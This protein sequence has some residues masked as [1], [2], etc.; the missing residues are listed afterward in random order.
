MIFQ[1]ILEIPSPLTEKSLE[2]SPMGRS[3]IKTPPT[4]SPPE[5]SLPGED[6]PWTIPPEHSLHIKLSSQRETKTN[7]KNPIIYEFQKITLCKNTK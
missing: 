5:N 7:K 6:L 3:P 4:E 2:N 1:I